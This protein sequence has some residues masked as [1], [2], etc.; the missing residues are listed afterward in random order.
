MNG[1]PV[2]HTVVRAVNVYMAAY[3]VIYVISILI[4]SLDNMDYT[5]N[6]TAVVATLNNI[7]P[8]LAKVGP[9][10]NFSI[11]STFSKIILSLDMLIGRLEIFPILVLFSPSA[12]RK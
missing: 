2:E 6:F 12:W 10:Q 9:T 5:T 3:I 11:F 8:G 1:R 4:I 7:G